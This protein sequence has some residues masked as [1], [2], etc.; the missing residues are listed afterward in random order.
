M[1][2]YRDVGLQRFVCYL[3]FVYRVKDESAPS[4]INQVTSLIV[5]VV[6]WIVDNH[7]RP[8]AQ[9][10]HQ[11]SIDDSQG[12]EPNQMIS[13]SKFQKAIKKQFQRS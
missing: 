5:L 12:T 4:L 11:E 7:H 1:D 2:A 3:L 10:R 8:V 6:I 9:C 13:R